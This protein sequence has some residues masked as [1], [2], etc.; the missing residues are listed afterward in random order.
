MRHDNHSGAGGFIASKAASQAGILSTA[1]DQVT[2]T[3]T[4]GCTNRLVTSKG[5]L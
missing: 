1:K 2:R 4:T 3:L 5:L